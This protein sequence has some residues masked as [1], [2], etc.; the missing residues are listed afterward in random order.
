MKVIFS[1][2]KFAWRTLNFI[3]DLVMNIVFLVFVLLLLTALPFV[4]GLDKQ[5]VALKGDQGALYFKPG[6]LFGGQTR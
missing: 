6:W 3:R 4:V 1:I 2:I 5:T